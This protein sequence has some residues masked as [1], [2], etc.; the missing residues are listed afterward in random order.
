[1]PEE[2]CLRILW[3]LVFQPFLFAL[4]GLVFDISKV[5]GF[6][7]FNFGVIVK[8]QIE[9]DHIVIAI[10]ILVIGK[11]IPFKLLQEEIL[12]KLVLSTRKKCFFIRLYSVG[13]PKS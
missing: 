1:M 8:F 9:L 6:Y 12:K 2:K 13:H 7:L 11:I 3:V 5:R 10:E 4:I